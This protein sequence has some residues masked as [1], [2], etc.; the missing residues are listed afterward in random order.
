MRSRAGPAAAADVSGLSE[1]DPELPEQATKEKSR[2][3]T[4]TGANRDLV[5][6]SVDFFNCEYIMS[7]RTRYKKHQYATFVTVR[8]MLII[9]KLESITR[10][11]A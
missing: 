7:P 9:V 4:T 1:S 3:S 8:L 6:W 5:L 2:A 11:E 10:Y